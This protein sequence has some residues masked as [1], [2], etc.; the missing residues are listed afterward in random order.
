MLSRM[1]FVAVLSLLFST[2][3]ARAE[4]KV[5]PPATQYWNGQHLAR[6]KH[7]PKSRSAE[8]LDSLRMLRKNA[9]AALKR[10]PYSVVDKEI[11]PPSGDKHD[12]LSFSRYW[13]PNPDT[14]DGLP[15]IRRDG[16]VNRELLANGD[17]VRLGEFCDD[18]E[19]LALAGYLFDDPSYADHAAHLI[20]VW[21]LNPAT[22]MNPN[23]N[24][25]QGVP[26]RS[27]G[28]APGIIDTR[29][30]LRV[31]DSILLL[32]NSSTLDRKEIVSLKKWFGEYLDWL[33]TSE[34]GRK[35]RA[36]KNNHGS[37]FAAQ[38][39][40]VCLFVDERE[41]AREIIRQVKQDRIPESIR[42]DGSQPEELGRTKTLHYSLFN[43]SALATL[44]RF[45][46]QLG[47]DMWNYETQQG[48]GIMRALDLVT[49][50]ITQPEEWPHPEMG[51]FAISDR[52]SQTL[53]LMSGVYRSDKL[54]KALQHAETRY[55]GRHLAPLLFPDWKQ[56]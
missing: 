10:G 12:Y 33:L 7:A 38:A 22:R 15:Y 6:V 8:V 51:K 21:Y 19:A 14:A 5:D 29:H 16:E 53:L 17:R 45:S 2:S 18:V 1:L 34:I 11:I 3:F 50:Y 46:D 40:G 35:E 32:E 13:W 24:F 30:F 20:R 43:L 9:N 26:G 36:A 48:T 52:L 47:V 49:P 55:E 28:R 56:R 54:T 37:W 31:I 23:V 27:H 44:A 4:V 39:V 42:P 25:G 41:T